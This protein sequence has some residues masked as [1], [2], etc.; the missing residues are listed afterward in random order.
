MNTSACPLCKSTE[1]KLLESISVSDLNNLYTRFYDIP[2]ALKTTH[3]DYRECE[4][5]K[6]R[7]FWP[8]E[9]G[10]EHLY[11][12]L[13]TFEW[14]YMDDKEEYQ[15]A[16]R[17]LPLDGKVLEVGSGKAAF[18][19]MVGVDRYTGLEFNDKAIERASLSKI[20]LLKE[21]VETHAAKGEQYDTVVSFQV[22]EHVSSPF[23][24]IKSCVDCLKTGGI[25]ILAVPSHDGFS[26]H[27]LNHILDMPP[28]HLSHWSGATL[29]KIATLF[30]LEMIFLEH[31]SIASYHKQW[32]RK[33]QI[34]SSIRKILGMDFKLIDYRLSARLISKISNFLSRFL[35]LSQ[36]E[37]KG[38]TVVAAYRKL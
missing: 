30:E 9:A 4:Y 24:F 28:H 14:Y 38:H 18:A 32:S 22:L 11:E 1:N 31:E 26:G 15:L 25:L 27:A 13:Q 29:Q 33:I 6:L 35:K 12:K 10:G 8:M 3:L 34:E 5:C 20:K 23:N 37:E 36:D 17:V 7:Y 2:K 16:L 19:S 21:S